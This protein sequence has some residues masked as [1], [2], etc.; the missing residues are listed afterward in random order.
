MTIY[1]NLDKY[2]ENFLGTNK[3]FFYLESGY[4]RYDDEVYKFIDEVYKSDLLKHDYM[5]YLED[6]KNLQTLFD[7][8]KTEEIKEYFDT[9]DYETLKVILT[10]YVRWHRFDDEAWKCVAKKGNF[11][12]LL[13][14]IKEITNTDK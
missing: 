8:I 11:H 13:I 7:I 2:I 4:P 14:R 9:V 5:I 1:D 6:L 10:Y 12:K 3:E